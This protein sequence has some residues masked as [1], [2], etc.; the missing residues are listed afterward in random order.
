MAE[1]YREKRTFF[2]VHDETWTALALWAI[3]G[4]RGI[5]YNVNRIF[6]TVLENPVVWDSAIIGILTAFFMLLGTATALKKLQRR[7]FLLVVFITMAWFLSYILN[8]D[9]RRLLSGSFFSPVLI[10]GS[11][12]II[13]ISHFTDW[14]KFQSVSMPF[15]MLGLLTFFILS[16]LNING[17]ITDQMG[18]GYMSFSY[19]NL[20]FVISAFWLAIH[21]KNIMFWGIA[22]VAM[23]IL[24]VTGSRGALLC[25][26]VYLLLELMLSK[27][28]NIAVKLLFF[29]IAALVFFNIEFIMG[30]IATVLD[31]YGYHSRTVEKF[32]EGTLQDD[33]G[34]GDILKCS[35]EVVL[36]NPIFGYG[37]AGSMPMLFEK[38]NGIKPI[39]TQG[40][41]AHNLFMDLLMHFGIFLGGFIC[42][43]LIYHLIKAYLKSRSK[44]VYNILFVFASLTLPKLM[45]TGTYLYDPEF[46]ILLGLIL[47]LSYENYD[48]L[49]KATE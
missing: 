25:V 19:N 4:L 14:K 38:I 7:E 30:K 31:E 21:K 32:F 15:T 43:W 6:N 8:E 1:L 33:S 26:L 45:I 40:T 34:R 28:T 47:N 3:I 44:K 29:V 18:I 39:G 48:E 42:I 20:V 2:G 23:V 36:E 22:P 46:F 11:C 41:Y 35:W 16:Y 24:M 49:P 10:Y 12:G 37:M 17:D 13:C 5:S 27:N 9:C